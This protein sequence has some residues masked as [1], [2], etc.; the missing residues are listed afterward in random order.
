M[1]LEKNENKKGPGLAHFKNNSKCVAHNHR[2]C[3]RLAGEANVI[4][5]FYD[6]VTVL[7]LKNAL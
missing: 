3:I 4:N 6:S 1:L 5:K 7:C 2:G